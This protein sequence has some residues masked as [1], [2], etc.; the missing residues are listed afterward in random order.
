[1]AHHLPLWILSS[2]LSALKEIAGYFRFIGKTEEANASIPI[3]ASCHYARHPV[4]RASTKRSADTVPAYW[5]IL[6]LA[7]S[8]IETGNP[9]DVT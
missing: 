3:H 1:V 4:S 7:D 8:C 2:I 6:F 5:R 9:F